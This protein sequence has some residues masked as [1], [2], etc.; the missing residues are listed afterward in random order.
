MAS[1]SPDLISP[2]S[3]A[4][5]QRGA[6]S[7]VVVVVVQV[8]SG[9]DEGLPL[10]TPPWKDSSSVHG[11]PSLQRLPLV[12]EALQ[13]SAA[14]LQDSVQSAAHPPVGGEAPGH[15]PLRRAFGI[16]Y[17]APAVLFGEF[18]DMQ[19]EISSDQRSASFAVTRS[20]AFLSR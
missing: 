12:S 11:W 14:S 16:A 10:Q 3:F 1:A 5:P 19:T 9:A 7:S 2:S 4:S 18:R 6:G 8:H 15:D 13:A 20:W 17:S